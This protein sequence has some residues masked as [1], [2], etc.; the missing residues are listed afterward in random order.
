MA[1]IA[2]T[3][4]VTRNEVVV[5]YKRLLIESYVCCITL[6]FCRKRP[7]RS[8]R[9][10]RTAPRG[11]RERP[12]VATP[13][14]PAFVCSNARLCRPDRRAPNTARRIGGVAHIC[15][16]AGAGPSVLRVRE[17][18]TWRLAPCVNVPRPH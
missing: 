13:I 4:S 15:D 17:V 1:A 6:A 18:S 12:A 14:S 16:G 2:I 3:P 9:G 8:K 11:Y 10:V 7:H 5:K